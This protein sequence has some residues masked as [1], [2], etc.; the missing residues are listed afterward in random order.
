MDLLEKRLIR[1]MLPPTQRSMQRPFRVD[2]RAARHRPWPHQ[3]A[4][5]SSDREVVLNALVAVA[6]SPVGDRSC[7][8][9]WGT[10]REAVAWA[11]R[12]HG[13]DESQLQRVMWL[14]SYFRY[15]VAWASAPRSLLCWKKLWDVPRPLD[16]AARLWLW[17]RYTVGNARRRLRARAERFLAGCLPSCQRVW[18]IRSRK[19]ALSLIHI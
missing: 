16:V 1:A 7:P 5:L 13:L 19:Q 8:R 14:D 6:G 3:R 2:R 9:V 12:C 17:G 15:L 18:H 10:W 4:A 11:R